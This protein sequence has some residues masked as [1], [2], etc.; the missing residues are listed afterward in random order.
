MVS[1]KG[2]GILYLS[3]PIIVPVW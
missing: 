2:G 1:E 3:F